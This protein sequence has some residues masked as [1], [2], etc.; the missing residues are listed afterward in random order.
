MEFRVQ[1]WELFFQSFLDS[2]GGFDAKQSVGFPFRGAYPF[3]VRVML[4]LH[5][6]VAKHNTLSPTS[7]LDKA[8][9]TLNPMSFV[10]R[11]KTKGV[12]ARWTRLGGF[13]KLGLPFSG[14]L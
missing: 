12:R 4:W 5:P 9:M 8:L 3:E 13:P 14:S 2:V 1:A 10:L 7:R 6:H 11:A